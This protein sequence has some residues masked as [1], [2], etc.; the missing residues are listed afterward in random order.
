MRPISNVVWNLFLALIPVALAFFIARGLRSQRRAGVPIVWALWI[1]LLLVWLVFLP[2]TCYLLT[3]WRHYLD[4]IG[5]SSGPVYFGARGSR[6]IFLDLLLLTGFYVVYTGSGL[7]TFFLAVWPLERLARRRLGWVV[8]PLQASVFVLCALGVYL[9]LVDRF[10]SWD[11]LHPHRLITILETSLGVQ[12]R[13]L[14]LGFILGFGAIL[15][16]LY[17]LFDIWM[18]GAAWR[19][20]TRRARASAS[21]SRSDQEDWRRASR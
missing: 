14:L 11:L 2:N 7:L 13:P 21:L 5:D 12:Q 9:G 3:E 15:G 17:T 20:Q 4:T 6:A 10:N 19:L 1:P 16:V 18:D 8:W